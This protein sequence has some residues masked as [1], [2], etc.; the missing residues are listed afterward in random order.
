M[1][2]RPNRT[3]IL[4]DSPSYLT[5]CWICRLIPKYVEEMLKSKPTDNSCIINWK[6]S[7]KVN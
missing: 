4:C 7:Y 3:C 6:N 5:I 1:S 2:D